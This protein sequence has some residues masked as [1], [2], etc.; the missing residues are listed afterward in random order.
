MERAGVSEAVGAILIFSIAALCISIYYTSYLRNAAS[1]NE[2][3]HRSQITGKFLSLGDLV[4]RLENGGQ[5]LITIPLS[6]EP[7]SGFLYSPPRPLAGRVEVENSGQGRLCYTS[8]YLYHSN[9]SVLFEGGGVILIQEGTPL[10]LS[11]PD[12]LRV[13]ENEVHTVEYRIS[14]SDRLSGTG[15]LTLRVRCSREET[16][17]WEN[18]YYTLALDNRTLPVWRSYFQQ[19]N[20]RLSGL[21]LSVEPLENGIS[22]RGDNLLWHRTVVELR[23]E[24]AG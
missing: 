9:F 13:T 12:L 1:R 5:I 15:N 7:V 20:R 10:M 23:I 14:G 19:E 17:L 24:L 4:G 3:S 8:G 2:A 18:V 6:P 21:P 16:Y 11:P 22:I